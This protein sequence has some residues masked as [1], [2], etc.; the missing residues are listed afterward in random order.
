[1]HLTYDIHIIFIHTQIY[2][3]TLYYIH[4]IILLHY[5]YYIG[6]AGGVTYTYQNYNL[7]ESYMKQLWFLFFVYLWT[8]GMCV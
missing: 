2:Y 5:I 8:T 6:H 3:Y 1:M 4:S 7:D